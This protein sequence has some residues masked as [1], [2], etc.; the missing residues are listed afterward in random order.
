MGFMANWFGTKSGASHAALAELM[1]RA[2]WHAHPPSNEPDDTQALESAL[3][4]QRALDAL[5]MSSATAAC[6]DPDFVPNQFAMK[7]ILRPRYLNPGEA[8]ARCVPE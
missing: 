5:G 8:M 3:A 6:G 2:T 4:L 7:P 1:P